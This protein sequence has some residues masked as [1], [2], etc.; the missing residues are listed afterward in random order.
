MLLTITFPRE[1][2]QKQT[3]CVG[4]TG[5]EEPQRGIGAI[6]KNGDKILIFISQRKMFN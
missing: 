2:S 3:E 1:F 6:L 5:Y 4:C